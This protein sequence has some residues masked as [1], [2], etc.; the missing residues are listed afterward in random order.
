[1]ANKL[2][3]THYGTKICVRFEVN[4]GNSDVGDNIQ[5]CWWFYD[6]DSFEML[7]TESLC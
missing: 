5:L 3:L 1:M 7:E 6:S 2:L 4:N